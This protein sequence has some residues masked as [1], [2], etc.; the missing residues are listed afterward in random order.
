MLRNIIAGWISMND[1]TREDLRE[2]I[3]IRRHA[4]NEL[5]QAGIVPGFV[6]SVERYKMQGVLEEFEAMEEW[7]GE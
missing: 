6:D 4:L 2:Y 1:F 5:L 3:R 7:F